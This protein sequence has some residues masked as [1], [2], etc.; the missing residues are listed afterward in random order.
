MI[1]GL[2][3]DH[4]EIL[5]KLGVNS[6]EDLASIKPKNLA[7]GFREYMKNIEDVLSVITEEDV[8]N[9]VKTARELME[10]REK[11]RTNHPKRLNR[12]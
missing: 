8:S 3:I 11:F 10:E 2:G 4:I 6:I 5:K 12:I 9:W 7:K 1:D